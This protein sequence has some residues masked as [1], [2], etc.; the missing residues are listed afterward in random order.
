MG[1]AHLLYIRDQLCC[2]L[3]VVCVGFPLRRLHG[4]HIQLIDANGGI[5]GLEPGPFL[6]KRLILPCKTAQVSD[7]GSILRPQLCG[8]SVRVR[9]QIS[10][11]ALELQLKLVIIA[12]LG[13][14]QEQF[15][16]PGIPQSSHLMNP[17]VPAVEI[18]HHAD[19][20]GIGGPDSE[21]SALHPIYDHG[22]RAQ[23]LINGIVNSVLEFLRVLQSNLGIKTVCLST[24]ALLP[25]FS[26]YRIMIYR[27]LVLPS[28][29]QRGK[30]T[31]LV[32]QLHLHQSLRTVFFRL[33]K[34]NG[35]FFR[36]GEIGL[37]ENL[38]PRLVRP[39]QFMRIVTF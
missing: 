35:S 39:Q 28:L 37:N 36:T 11:P 5:A 15:K 32:R 2:N 9:L 38:V 13:I 7:D 17:A 18:S 4:T 1:I 12:G 29:H 27:Q 21:V 31:V 24:D 3:T 33:I 19:A 34:Y 14:G 16:N 22:M 26:L 6:Q 25:V 23:L 20:H 30:K 8:I 10:K